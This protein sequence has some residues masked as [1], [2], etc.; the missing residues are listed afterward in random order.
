MDKQTFD[1]LMHW[2][3]QGVIN[4]SER[5]GERDGVDTDGC[6]IERGSNIHRAMAELCEAVHQGQIGPVS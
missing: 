4:I 1:D 5:E 2:I 6:F 3:A